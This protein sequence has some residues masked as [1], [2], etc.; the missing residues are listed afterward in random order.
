MTGLSDAPDSP[1]ADRAPTDR[2]PVLSRRARIEQE[3][4][5]RG[6]GALLPG[7]E[8]TGKALLTA[9]GGVRGLLESVLPGFAFLVVFAFTREIMVSVAWPLVISLG[10]FAARVIQH[11]S[12][13]TALAG[14][15]GVGVSAIAAIMTGNPNDNFLPGIIVNAVFLVA[16]AVSLLLRWPLVGFVLGALT[17]RLTEWHEDAHERRAAFAATLI[18][19]AL[20]AARLL[21]ELPLYFAGLTEA[22]ALAKLL[23]GVPLYAAALWLTWLL[24]RRP[25]ASP[26]V[27][28]EPREGV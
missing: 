9:L 17:S 24:L 1:Q 14:V 27:S 13:M 2:E 5:N 26:A 20:F 15:I 16:I 12:P 4:A 25:K 21:V 28:E 22:L 3:R 11:S 18:W 10:F 8:P 19:G 6:L 23:M 7:E